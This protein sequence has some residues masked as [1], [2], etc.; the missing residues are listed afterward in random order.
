[1]KITQDFE[2]AMKMDKIGPMFEAI[3]QWRG[4]GTT[5]KITGNVDNPKLFPAYTNW[6]T[7]MA[8]T[9]KIL[10]ALHATVGAGQTEEQKKSKALFDFGKKA[11]GLL[12]DL[13]CK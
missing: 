2:E 1:V 8:E 11:V 7:G 3:N 4:T 12:H 9:G 6:Y 10:A 13:R 5:T